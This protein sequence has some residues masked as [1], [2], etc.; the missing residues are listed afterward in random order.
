MGSGQ[1]EKVVVEPFFLEGGEVNT[2]QYAVL[3]TFYF[4]GKKVR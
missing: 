2:D 3:C 4:Q 1:N